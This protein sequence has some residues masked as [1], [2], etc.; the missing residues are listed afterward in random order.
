MDG[1]NK[2]NSQPDKKRIDI[3]GKE[4]YYAENETG[5]KTLF[6]KLYGEIIKP[7]NSI[8]RKLCSLIKKADIS[9]DSVYDWIEDILPKYNYENDDSIYTFLIVMFK[10]KIMDVRK[11]GKDISINEKNDEGKEIEVASDEKNPEEIFVA[12]EL[13]SNIETSLLSVVINFYKHNKGKSANET[14]YSYFR[15]FFTEKLII[16]LDECGINKYMNER[17]CYENSDKDLVRF[18]S[19]SEYK[20]LKDLLS[21]DFKKFSDVIDGYKDDSKLICVPFE[22]EIIAE[23]RYKNA[24]DKAK[25][26]LSN[27]SQQRTVFEEQ[28]RRIG[29]N[30][31]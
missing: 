7:E 28:L 13:V 23:Y 16:L 3:L 30:H 6:F 21:L 8:Y 22:N 26:S 1:V 9:T 19:F 18:V 29:L 25:V 27:V 14:R 17:E 4:Y 24:L 20:E 31:A 10:Y 12:E 11:K 5:K 2:K 15:I